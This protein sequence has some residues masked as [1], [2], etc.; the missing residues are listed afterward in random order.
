M[1]G[2][3][4]PAT[5]CGGNELWVHG[6]L[7]GLAVDESYANGGHFFGGS[8]TNIVQIGLPADGVAYAHDL[9]GP[10][11]GFLAFPTAAPHNGEVLCAA[12]ATTQTGGDEA[13]LTLSSLSKAGARPGTPVSGTLELSDCP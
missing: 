4:A 13:V 5:A 3:S 7:D 1:P 9:G 6:T 12:G 8:G 10:L 2:F 11:A